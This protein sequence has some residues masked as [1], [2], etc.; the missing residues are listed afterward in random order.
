MEKLHFDTAHY[1][2][3]VWTTPE[4]LREKLKTRI[5]AVIG[6]GPE[7]PKKH[8]TTL[9]EADVEQATLNWLYSLGWTIAA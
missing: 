2:H 3:I 5:L 9:T 6:E 7:S 1:N 8:L 4:E